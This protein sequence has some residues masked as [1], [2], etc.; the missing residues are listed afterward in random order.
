M[1]DTSLPRKRRAPSR[2]KIG[3]SEGY[4]HGSVKEYYCQQYFECLDLIIGTIRERFNHPGYGVL[5]QLECLLLKA[6]KK[7]EYHAELDLVLKH[8][9][10]DI[11]H[12]A[13]K[14]SLS[15]CQQ[16]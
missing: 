12:Q 10:T 14:Y 1:K 9:H 3:S 15:C 5:K 6:A 13:L 4:H 16:C 7:E 8:Y 2:F 11:K